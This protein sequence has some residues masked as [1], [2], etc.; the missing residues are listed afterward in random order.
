MFFQT[1]QARKAHHFRLQ[2]NAKQILPKGSKV[3]FSRRITMKAPMSPK[4]FFFFCKLT[5]K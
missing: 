2:T 3:K 4:P 1:C 5:K